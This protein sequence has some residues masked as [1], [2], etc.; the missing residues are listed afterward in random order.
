MSDKFAV[1]MSDGHGMCPDCG[2]FECGC[3]EDEGP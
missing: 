1:R 2:H 3:I